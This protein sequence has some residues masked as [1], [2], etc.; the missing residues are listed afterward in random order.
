MRFSYQPWWHLMPVQMTTL[1]SN[2]ALF[3]FSHRVIGSR[4]YLKQKQVNSS[5]NRNKLKNIAEI[6]LHKMQK[7]SLSTLFL[8]VHPCYSPSAAHLIKFLSM[9]YDIYIISL[10]TCSWLV[11]G[12]LDIYG[13]ESFTVNSLEQLCINYANERL[14]QHFVTHFL[15]DLQVRYR[16]GDGCIGGGLKTGTILV[17]P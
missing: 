7:I 10:L 16:D 9:Y 1:C 2:P 12:I 3:K 4:G 8:I 5:L 14:Q 11:A 17:S 15:R 6:K 13:F